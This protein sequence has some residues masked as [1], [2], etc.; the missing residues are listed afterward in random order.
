MRC[1]L[2]V[3]SVRSGPVNLP[4][5]GALGN[6]C[7]TAPREVYDLARSRNGS[8]HDQRPRHDRR[9]AGDRAP[10]RGLPERGSH[11]E[12]GRR[13]HPALRSAGHHGEATPGAWPSGA[14][15]PRPFFAYCSE[16]QI[17]LALN[18]PFSLAIGRRAAEDFDLALSHVSFVETHNGGM[19]PETNL[20]AQVTVRAH[21][22]RGRGWQ[23]RPLAPRDRP[24]LDRG[25]RRANQRGVPR[26]LAQRLHRPRRPIRLVSP[27]N[28]GCS[29]RHPRGIPPRCRQ[30]WAQP[31]GCRALR[32]AAGPLPLYPWFP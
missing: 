16:A 19:P 4:L 18:H 12:P 26:R 17:P 8:G 32:C 5:L 3:H 6:E 7:Y 31:Q 25:A 22:L 30:G 28:S 24:H 11:S 2:H 15:T 14:T 9:G 20:C 21:G 13:A 23:R 27:V 1:D 10:P 29:R